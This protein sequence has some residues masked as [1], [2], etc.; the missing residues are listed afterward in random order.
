M[1]K[2]VKFILIFTMI[3][4]LVGALSACGFWETRITS[5]TIDN[6][7][8]ITMIVGETLELSVT[9]K[10]NSRTEKIQFKAETVD[11]NHNLLNDGSEV[12]TIDEKGKIK[13]I[14]DGYAKVTVQTLDGRLK[15][16]V[17][18][19]ATYAPVKEF[20]LNYEGKLVQYLADGDPTEIKL[21]LTHGEIEVPKERIITWYKKVGAEKAV[22]LT[23]FADSLTATVK[24]DSEVGY[25]ATVYAVME[26]SG[27]KFTSNELSYGYFRRYDTRYLTIDEPTG[28]IKDGSD[29]K[30]EASGVL[31]TNDYYFAESGEEITLTFKESVGGTNPDPNCQWFVLTSDDNFT[32]AQL[33]GADETFTVIEGQTS[34]VLRFTP[35]DAGKRYAIRLKCDG[36][37]AWR[38]FLFKSTTALVKNLTLTDTDGSASSIQHVSSRHEITL[39]AD[40]NKTGTAGTEYIKWF[41]GETL[42]KQ[43]K[44]TDSGILQ[45]SFTPTEPESEIISGKIRVV[46]YDYYNESTD[47]YS[48]T[49][50]EAT[51]NWSVQKTLFAPKQTKVELISGVQE[52]TDG[53]ATEVVF[54]ASITKPVDSANVTLPVYWYVNGTLVNS[55]Y[56][57]DVDQTEKTLTF[58]PSTSQ[59]MEYAVYAIIGNVKSNT[60][61][62]FRFASGWGNVA[63]YCR[64]KFE[65]EGGSFNR[66]ISSHIEAC[67]AF[68]YV[69][70][71]YDTVGLDFYIDSSLGYNSDNF[72]QI[73]REILCN[74]YSG[75][76]MP[77]SYS[78][79][80][81][82]LHVNYN[83][84]VDA[85]KEPTT[86][87]TEQGTRDSAYDFKNVDVRYNYDESKVRSSLPIDDNELS[88][89]VKTSDALWRAVSF[90]YKPIVADGTSVKTVY[91]RARS[92]AK[93][94]CTDSMTDLEKVKAICDWLAVNV[95]YDYTA[96]NTSMTTQEALRYSCYY[97]E[98][99]FS[100]KEEDGKIVW[101]GLAVCDG[102]S[103]AFVLL[104]G[105]ENI[106]A[107]RVVGTGDGGNH[108][109]NKALID[110]DENGE[111]E[112][113]SFDITWT[114]AKS[115]GSSVEHYYHN[116]LFQ[117][118]NDMAAS[119][120]VERN[121]DC[122][123]SVGEDSKHVV[124]QLY[125]TSVGVSLDV[126]S[127]YNFKVNKSYLKGNYDTSCLDGDYAVGD[128]RI[129]NATELAIALIH[130]YLQSEARGMNVYVV[131]KAGNYK[132]ISGTSINADLLRSA[133]SLIDISGVTIN[134]DSS[135]LNNMFNSGSAN[136]DWL[137]RLIYT[138]N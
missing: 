81:N 38:E 121:V 135:S 18:I 28:F 70:V 75:G 122:V 104:C 47:I 89:S 27:L 95:V 119:K 131:L 94:I 115:S 7:S 10:P 23:E 84:S 80:G 48:D 59:N 41:S 82:V 1:K 124:L 11:K 71:N 74:Y 132:F 25:Y 14:D 49:Y 17:F 42:I 137:I 5:L 30:V 76:S 15:E 85:V 60:E 111:A 65:W 68:S 129:D 108:A 67:I 136:G 106:K 34:K 112:W 36:V 107:V 123:Y 32:K 31:D 134:S 105:L 8:D 96:A 79:N 9:V 51:Y 62:V 35:K 40:W 87:T 52:Q 37:E 110:A 50:Q 66:Y 16:S 43:G 57:Y 73:Y 78:I 117:S 128:G 138:K 114:S 55:V 69:M 33:D 20:N 100:Q 63:S 91:E 90:G 56:G 29:F 3:A 125:P 126:H 64:D 12:V 99:V 103:K 102:I 61:N 4:L 118:E 39:T 24:A 13:A 113:Y 98:G 130:S 92:V 46:V 72:G 83:E 53:S 58:T 21:N 19:T 6:P 54:K 22:E 133:I 93:Q 77:I 116:Y 120:H 44:V 2:A 101:D 26:Y 97:L 45:Y 88:Y 86:S 127:V 109:W